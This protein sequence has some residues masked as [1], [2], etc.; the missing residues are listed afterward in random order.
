MFLVL[1]SML[2][3][4]EIDIIEGVHD[5]IHNQVTFHTRDGCNLTYPGNFTG[6][7]VVGSEY[8]SPAYIVFMQTPLPGTNVLRCNDQ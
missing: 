2:Q 8:D 6:T 1:V 5:N 7:L 3:N 4:G